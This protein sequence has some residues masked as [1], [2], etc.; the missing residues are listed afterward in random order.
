[1]TESLIRQL[2][3]MRA[4]MRAYFNA[5]GTL[6][7]RARLKALKALR[8]GLISHEDR[9]LEAVRQDL[10]RS[11]Q[12]TFMTELGLVR[13]EISLFLRKLKGW[14][15][16]NRASRKLFL[17]PSHADH[18]AQPLGLV[19]IISPWNFPL[20]LSLVPLVG[21][22]GAGN[23]AV[24]R[25]SSRVS[26]TSA[27]LR[28]LVEECLPAELAGVILC[29]GHAMQPV[30]ERRWDFIMFTGSVPVGRQIMRAAAEHL[31]PLALE[32][33]GKSPVIVHKDA[34][35]RLAARRIAWGKTLNAGQVCVAPDYLLLHEERAEAVLQ[36]LRR[37][38]IRFWGQAPLRNP[39]YTRII[40]TNAMERLCGYLEEGRVLYGGGHDM[41][42]RRFEPTLLLMPRVE[43]LINEAAQARDNYDDEL[44]Y[45]DMPD[46]NAMHYVPGGRFA[47]LRDEIFGPVLPVLLYR[48]IKACSDFIRLRPRPL[49]FYCFSS[50]RALTS[51]L[52]RELHYGG[53]CV[54]DCVL[55][56]SHSGLPMGGIGGSGFG[57]YHGKFSFETFSQRKGILD[58]SSRFDSALR[59]PPYKNTV[60]RWLRWLF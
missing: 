24:L 59:F 1:M 8:D 3:A 7:V 53:G 11:A 31:T 35:P 47:V 27:A 49:A 45:A 51:E 33:G 48:N 22:I 42:E 2:E 39:K 37:D 23:C 57:R 4:R 40:S 36:Y 13:A 58:R 52:M 29:E 15:K 12:E 16:P 44:P 5:G 21:A 55:H 17:F 26:A 9:L 18:V 32:L 30:L 38:F 14:A 6:P 60:S 28:A 46:A 20:L 19:L 10:G 43:E 50:N 54:N 56:I 41:E 34:D 25:P